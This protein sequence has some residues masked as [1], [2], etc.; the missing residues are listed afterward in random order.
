MVLVDPGLPSKQ[1]PHEEK[2]LLLPELDGHRV[3]SRFLTKAD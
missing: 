2:A 1:L 3:D